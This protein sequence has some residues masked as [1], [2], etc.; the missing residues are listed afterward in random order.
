[1]EKIYKTVATDKQTGKNVLI[2]M[3]HVNKKAF[4]EDLRANGYKVND[5]K[6]RLADEWDWI[7]DNTNCNEWDW[8][9]KRSEMNLD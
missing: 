5:K 9:I 4:I 2:E 6:V 7:V 8:K 1:M 3:S